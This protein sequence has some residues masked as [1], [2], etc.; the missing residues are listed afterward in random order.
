MNKIINGKRYDTETAQYIHRVE[1]MPDMSNFHWCAETLYRKKTGE[2]FI[3]GEGNAASKYARSIGTNSW[4][5]GERIMPMSYSEAKEWAE[6]HMTADEYE[7]IFGVIDENDDKS[8]R[9][10]TLTTTTLNQIDKL[11]AYLVKNKNE[12]IT[13]AIEQFYNGLKDPN[14]IKRDLLDYLNLDTSAEYIKECEDND[15]LTVNIGTDG[16]TYY[17]YLDGDGREGAMD[18]YGNLVDLNHLHSVM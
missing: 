16:K 12:I 10:Y 11:A 1:N 18:I 6:E 3:Y 13:M 8:P 4:G 2:F 14:E 15:D 9:T 5:S 17:W 7:N